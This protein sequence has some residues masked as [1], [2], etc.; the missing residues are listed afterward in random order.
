MTALSQAVEAYPWDQ[1]SLHRLGDALKFLGKTAESEAVR[2]REA[3]YEAARLTLRGSS[4]P[5]PDVPPD[6][7]FDQAL[8]RPDLGVTPDP[9]LY[10]RF[11]TLREQM[12]H[13]DEAL[14][15]YRLTLEADPSDA[16]SR[17]AVGRLEQ[18]SGKPQ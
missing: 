5:R 15:W 6:G 7:L 17:T 2:Q 11:A 14:A 4:T 12:G 1:K 16:E 9:A 18:R 3:D 8:S 13:P 10:K